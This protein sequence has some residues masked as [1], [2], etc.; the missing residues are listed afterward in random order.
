QTAKALVF[1]QDLKEVN[2]TLKA[3]LNGFT[4]DVKAFEDRFS[5][6]LLFKSQSHVPNCW[7]SGSL[8]TPDDDE[9]V[10]E[11][12][13]RGDDGG[14]AE[15]SHLF[16]KHPYVATREEGTESVLSPRA[17]SSSSKNVIS[18]S[19]PF[20]NNGELNFVGPNLEI[21]DDGSPSMSHVSDSGHSHSEPIDILR[22]VCENL[23][24]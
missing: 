17:E 10:V 13:F 2:C 5:P 8:F 23:P 1:S 16:G 11:D 24:V 12:T 6:S 18:A 20:S 7:D 3:S 19:L 22:P 21:S 15:N 9:P 14:R 4:F